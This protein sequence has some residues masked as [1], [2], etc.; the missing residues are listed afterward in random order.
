L[1]YC[2]FYIKPFGPP[3]EIAFI[4]PNLIDRKAERKAEVEDVLLGRPP[5][6]CL[7]MV[8]VMRFEKDFYLLCE[9]CEQFVCGLGLH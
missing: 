8:L 6:M 7:K 2:L 5:Q 3:Y 4:N 9:E 1:S